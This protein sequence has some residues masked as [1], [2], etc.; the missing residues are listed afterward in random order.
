ME[1]FE[2]GNW[3]FDDGQVAWVGQA[4][5]LLSRC[6]MAVGTSVGEYL[7]GPQLCE[8]YLWAELQLVLVFRPPPGTCPSAVWV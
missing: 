1:V 3:G 7:A 5:R 6:L 4:V 2:T 8:K